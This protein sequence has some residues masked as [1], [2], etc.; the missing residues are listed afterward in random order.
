MHLLAY[1]IV[2]P[3]LYL[4]SLFPLR[5]LYFFSDVAYYVVYKLIKYRV[6]TV[7][8]N[9][10][11]AFPEKSKDELKQIEKDF[12]H[13]F[14]DIFFELIKSITISKKELLKRYRLTNPEYLKSCQA[15]GKSIVLMGAHYANWEWSSVLTMHFIFTG[16]GIYKPLSNKYFDSFVK[17]IRKRFKTELI[18]A[19]KATKIILSH[20]KSNTKGIYLFLSDQ[21]PVYKKNNHWESFMG[22]EVPVFMGAEAMARTFDF[23]VL[24]LQT[25]R[26]KRGYYTCELLPISENMKSEPLYKPT[27]DFFDLVEAQIKQNPSMYFW[28]H[29]RW[30]HKDLPR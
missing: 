2:V 22:V 15:K 14:C 10:Q 1:L 7:S 13:H 17:K 29:K 6:K 5:I 21:S 8:E 12:Y 20:Q 18:S 3:I 27:R 16:Y 19:Y 9:L 26:V 28:T 11:L 4:L 23:T 30:K 24:Y 25:V